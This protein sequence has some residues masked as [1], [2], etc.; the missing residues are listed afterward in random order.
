ML[1]FVFYI[2]ASAIW[3]SCGTVETYYE[4]DMNFRVEAGSRLC[5]F[6]EG[7]AGQ[8]M[9]IQYEVTDGQHGDW[10]ISFEVMDPNGNKLLDDYKNTRNSVIFDLEV[11]GEYVFCLDNTFSVMNSK[12]VFVYVLIENKQDEMEESE[13]SVVD[14]QGDE[15][16]EE[17]ILEWEG[18][19]INGESY[20][21]EVTKI[22][23][24]LTRILKH[25]LKAR[26]LLDVYGVSKTRDSYLANE[27]TFIVDMWSGF[28][29]SF[30]F[31]VGLLQVYMIKKLFDN[32]GRATFGRC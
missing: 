32:P 14:D 13:V 7:K 15:H 28:Q 16:P 10:D 1:H 6:E 31:V 17:Q 29:I 3:R 19:D 25:V 5:F 2:L 30:M 12:L 24:C 26:H 8:M 27:D 9:E 21:I 11:D 20:Y 4:N 18:V 23:D 22:I